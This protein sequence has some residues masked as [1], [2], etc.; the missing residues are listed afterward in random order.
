MY[1]LDKLK[2]F[3]QKEHFFLKRA[4]SSQLNAL[5]PGFQ[6]P[7]TADLFSELIS[8]HEINVLF[9]ANV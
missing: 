7:R 1:L 5:V 9:D 8:I 2:P 6:E 3:E 4:K